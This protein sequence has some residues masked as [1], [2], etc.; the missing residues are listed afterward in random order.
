MKKD[1]KKYLLPPT[2]HIQCFRDFSIHFFPNGPNF[3]I[4]IKGSSSIS[5]FL[6]DPRDLVATQWEH[7]GLL[8]RKHATSQNK[9][10]TKDQLLDDYSKWMRMWQ[11]IL[12]DS[13]MSNTFLL[14]NHQN[15]SPSCFPSRG[16]NLGSLRSCLDWLFRSHQHFFF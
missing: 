14:Y 5:I 7:H 2:K 9:Q 10:K 16:A 1:I 3:K 11:P 13:C 8:R 4:S 12:L 6:F 15:F